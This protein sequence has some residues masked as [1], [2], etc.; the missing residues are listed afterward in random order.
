[1]TA[2]NL[3]DLAS[4]VPVKL[5]DKVAFP[6]QAGRPR[7]ITV[8]FLA[9]GQVFVVAKLGAVSVP[10][11]GG[12]G[13]VELRFTAGQ[14]VE[15][16]LSAAPGTV[17]SVKR[18]DA[19]Q[20]V[21][22]SEDPSYTTIEPQRSEASQAVRRIEHVM[23]MNSLARERQLLDEIRNLHEKGTPNVELVEPSVPSAA[24]SADPAPAPA[25][26]D[27]PADG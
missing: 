9:N 12:S 26:K 5:T 16:S 8:E 1:M 19:S 11:G 2:I 17:V 25:A 15:L 13:L 14:D 20:V 22:A 3:R 6:V 7:D 27:A 23:R 4:W 10:L 24:A 21:P 18:Q